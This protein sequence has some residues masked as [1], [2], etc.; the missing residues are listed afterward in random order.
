MRMPRRT[1]SFAA[2]CLAAVACAQIG[3]KAGEAQMQLVPDGLIPPSPA[4][5][6]QE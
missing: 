4:L 1:L 6:P 5:T 3:D 2:L